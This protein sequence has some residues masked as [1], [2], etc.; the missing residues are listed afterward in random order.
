ME[1]KDSCSRPH[2][3]ELKKD[4]VNVPPYRRLILAFLIFVSQ[5]E[6]ILYDDEK[7][8]GIATND[9]GIAKDGS[10]RDN[11]QCGVELKGRITLLGEGCR[12]SLSEVQ[13]Q[14]QT[15]ALGIKEVGQ[16]RLEI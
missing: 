1:K 3:M 9:M 10:R 6:N 14:H 12:G 15:Y 11:F 7:V 4:T 2:L 16:C 5:K 8:I 13:G